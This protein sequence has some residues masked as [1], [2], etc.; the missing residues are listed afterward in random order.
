MHA[1]GGRV[2]RIYYMYSSIATV[3]GH[4]MK[5]KV[6]FSFN[7]CALIPFWFRKVIMIVY[8]KCILSDQMLF[9]HSH[10]N[11]IS[12]GKEGIKER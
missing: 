12:R 5:I 6:A 8:R 4:L 7:D 1:V 11:L 10:D 2:H 3:K 9:F